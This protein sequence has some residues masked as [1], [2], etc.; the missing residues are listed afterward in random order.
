M[1]KILRSLYGLKQSARDWNQLLKSMMLKWGFTQSLADP[2]LFVHRGR[3]LMILVYVDDIAAAGKDSADLDWFFAQL[4]GRFTAK[5]LG[6]I[7]QFLGIRITRDRKN[8]TLYLDQE[9]YL[10]KTLRKFEIRNAKHIPISTPIDNYNDLCIATDND[11][12]INF[13]EYA[14]IIESLIFTIVYTHLD[15]TF[16]LGRLS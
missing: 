1:L 3:G 15:I 4:T 13:T 7:K 6:E 8:H 10:D 11:T 14:M 2:C 5:D 9:K 16:A 12:R